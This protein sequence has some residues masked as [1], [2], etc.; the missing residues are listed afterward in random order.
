MTVE[1]RKISPSPTPTSSGRRRAP[2]TR[3]C[4]SS[5]W[6]DDER[7]VALEAGVGGLHGL[8]EI[9]RDRRVR[10]R[11]ATTSASV[12]ELKCSPSASSIRS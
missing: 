11:W 1:A 2:P 7:E 9:A 6:I 10:S 5:R 3:R 12:S 8:E 4:G